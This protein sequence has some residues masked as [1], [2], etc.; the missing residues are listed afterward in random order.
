MHKV[1]QDFSLEVCL[2]INDDMFKCFQTGRKFG[3]S[4]EQLHLPYQI[5]LGSLRV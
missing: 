2:H 1:Q 5:V 3:L 4:I